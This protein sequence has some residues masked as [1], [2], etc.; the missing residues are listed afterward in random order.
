MINDGQLLQVI[1]SGLQNFAVTTKTIEVTTHCDHYLDEAGSQVL[2]L[3]FGA[4]TRWIENH[5]LKWFQLLGPQGFTDEIAAH[6]MNMALAFESRREVGDGRLIAVDGGE[7][8]RR[9]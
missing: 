9:K 2:R 1:I 5:G 3:R 6:D 7:P 4:I 8:A